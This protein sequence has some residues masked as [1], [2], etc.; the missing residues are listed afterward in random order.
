LKH[1][2]ISEFDSPDLKDSG[3]KMD[4]IF[5]NLL[6]DAREKAGVP[7]KIL[8]GYRTIEHNMLVGGRINSS[9]LFGL[10]ADIYLPKSSRNRFL[11]INS[12][13]EVGFNRI[14][15]DFNR[16]FVHVDMDRSKDKNVLWTYSN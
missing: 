3:Q 12:L 5:L 15:I 11:I 14:G 10:A 9:H 2:K 1:F 13:F 6:D 8:S 16:G 4:N 7:F